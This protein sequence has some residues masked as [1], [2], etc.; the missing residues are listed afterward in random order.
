APDDIAADEHEPTLFDA[1][2]PSML[3][4][5]RSALWPIVALAVLIGVAIGVGGVGIVVSY[6]TAFKDRQAPAATTPAAVQPAP[7]SAAAPQA[8]E[9]TDSAVSDAAMPSV[10]STPP[11]AA[12][13]PARPQPAAPASRAAVPNRE[14]APRAAAAASRGLGRILVRSTPAGARVSVDGRDY[15]VTP[16]AVRDLS[17]GTHAIRITRDGFSAEERRVR[18]T[19]SRPSHSLIVALERG[20]ATAAASFT[21]GLT[22]D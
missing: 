3:D 12:P 17:V 8:R 19:R 13:A 9:Y 6:L 7:A 2:P 15:G 21:G 20:R 1:P 10:P 11:A 4:R 18:I 22:I 16:L 5:S 14:P